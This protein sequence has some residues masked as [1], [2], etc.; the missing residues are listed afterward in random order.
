MKLKQLICFSWNEEDKVKGFHVFAQSKGIDERDIY[1][2]ASR[3]AYRPSDNLTSETVKNLAETSRLLGYPKKGDN[4]LHFAV[5]REIDS[6]FP[7]D[8]AFFTL[9][10]GLLCCAK[11]TYCGVDYRLNVWGNYIIHAYIF[12]Y[13]PKISPASILLSQ[14]FKTHLTADD[15][16]PSRTQP[17][18]PEIEITEPLSNV[19]ALAKLVK[20]RG[21]GTLSRIL[22]CV[23]A[24]VRRDMDIYINAP[25]KDILFWML[26][27]E[28]LLPH[29]ITMLLSFSTCRFS[30]EDGSPF[31]IKHI[32]SKLGSHYAYK[33]SSSD[34]T[35][36]SI[37]PKNAIF[38]DSA[39][40]LQLSG[41][42]TCLLLTAPE[43]IEVIRSLIGTYVKT[44]GVIDSDEICLIYRLARTDIY[45][46]ISEIELCETLKDVVL[47]SFGYDTVDKVIEKYLATTADG[48][49]KIKLYGHLAAYHSRPEQIMTNMFYRI[50]REL[51][52]GRMTAAEALDK[53]FEEPF[54]K[55]T[56]KYII[57]TLD[58]RY[59]LF[60]FGMSEGTTRSFIYKLLFSGFYDLKEEG[61]ADMLI[62]LIP[63]AVK[64]ESERDNSV[65]ECITELIAVVEFDESI[66]RRV[67]YGYYDY[68]RSDLKE[69]VG[70]CG[71]ITLLFEQGRKLNSEAGITT[72]IIRELEHGSL[73]EYMKTGS[74]ETVTVLTLLSMLRRCG[75]LS[76]KAHANFIY[77][78]FRDFLRYSADCDVISLVIDGLKNENERLVE[79]LS[80]YSGADKGLALEVY[81]NKV[82]RTRS[83][84][85]NL[86]SAMHESDIRYIGESIVSA[87]I[88]SWESFISYLKDWYVNG[89]YNK[90]FQRAFQR[91]FSDCLENESWYFINEVFS[92]CKSRFS[93]SE[94]GDLDLLIKILD[95]NIG[96][97]IGKETNLLQLLSDI[98]KLSGSLP[99]ALELVIETELTLIGKS[100]IFLPVSIS[101]V[102]TASDTLKNTYVKVYGTRLVDLCVGA[103][104]SE[105]ISSAVWL[106]VLAS[107]GNTF[108]N[109][110][111]YISRLASGSVRIILGR[112]ISAGLIDEDKIKVENMILSLSRTMKTSDYLMLRKNVSSKH[113][114]IKYDIIFDRV[115]ESFGIIAKRKLALMRKDHK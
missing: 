63:A 31:R 82:S 105:T 5:Q 8:C 68:C 72:F 42:I 38:S 65:P 13:D 89:K 10:S 91:A 24:A 41:L 23:F 29:D 12:S 103:S 94:R 32:I 2:I 26:A 88:T 109:I 45:D 30:Q 48:S 87:R 78:K 3:L 111:K 22:D 39:S 112:V 6:T 106:V 25:E 81:K 21:A 100:D 53:L 86:L 74:E 27:C 95:T 46:G 101:F 110:V 107:D 97:Y 77:D 84:D 9:P 85:K 11:V 20:A 52:D 98:K 36:I 80:Q 96:S 51:S 57:D 47:R 104:D 28:T 62:R 15:L 43:E 61:S 99:T 108:A 115:E 64:Y 35:H 60:E 16:K 113:Q 102:Q 93:T 54:G 50:M 75:A 70:W 73:L 69:F 18:I 17:Y 58:T 1:A 56:V 19:D 66:Y 49:F 44:H 76:E 55:E 79:A 114:N 59:E 4:G 40:K 83:A 7:T 71:L 67:I 92:I 90:C 37:D 34:N 33:L 14:K